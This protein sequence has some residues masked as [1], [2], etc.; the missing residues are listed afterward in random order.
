MNFVDRID[1]MIDQRHLLGHSFYRKW[2][3]GTLPTEALKE[4]ARQYYAF[5][6][7]FPRFLSTLHARSDQPE[8]RQAL[9]EN[10][11][12]EEH[13]DSNH[14]E[15]WLRF[16]EGIGVDRDDVRG[17]D[18]NERTQALVDTYWRTCS[19]A[20]VAAGVAAVYAYERQVPQVAQA[21]IDGL[22]ARY[23]IEDDRTLR[24]FDL[25]STLDVEH[26]DAERLMLS[27]ASEADATAVVDSAAAAL[28]AWWGF[29]D[30][31]DPVP[32]A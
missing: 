9:L 6:S 24:F 2:V 14:A 21:K 7:T 19:E 3:A 23:G 16:A 18:R 8:V 20:P 10:L 25:H 26:S 29:L 12:D 4:Y 15:L 30:G 28:E 11:W 1:A 32:A 5:E 17:A 13:G 22:R 31:V 27:R